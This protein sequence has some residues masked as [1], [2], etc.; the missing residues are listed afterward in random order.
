MIANMFLVALTSFTLLGSEAGQLLAT[1]RIRLRSVRSEYGLLRR[2]VQETILGGALNRIH[3]RT[4]AGLGPSYASAPQSL[5]RIETGAAALRQRYWAFQ[6]E[7]Q[8]PDAPVEQA[9]LRYE[10]DETA[11]RNAEGVAA[12]L[13]AA[14]SPHVSDSAPAR[15]AMEGS[16]PTVDEPAFEGALLGKASYSRLRRANEEVKRV[17]ERIRPGLIRFLSRPAGR[18]VV[19]RA[20]SC[21]RLDNAPSIRR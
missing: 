5:D 8:V 20:S 9:L 18:E 10:R 17:S 6:Q 21:P 19:L 13:I 2:Q 1:L 4:V 14:A 12:R 11:R 15:S 16:T 3:E 7:Y